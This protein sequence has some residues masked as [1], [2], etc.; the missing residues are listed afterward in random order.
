[1]R[2][3]SLLLLGLG[4]SLGA[5]ACGDDETGGSGGSGGAGGAGSTTAATTS[6]TTSSTSTGGEGGQ[7]GGEGGQ[8]GEGGGGIPIARG[9]FDASW[10]LSIAGEEADCFALGAEWVDVAARPQGSDG[11]IVETR[12]ACGDGDGRTDE[13]ALGA[14][15]L[16]FTLRSFDEEPVADPV[17][18]T[19]ELAEDGGTVAL[20]PIAFAVD[21]ARFDVSWIL[22][23]GGE[24]ATCE[25]AGADV[26][27]LVLVN[28]DTG[29]TYGETWPCPQG[30]GTTR[31]LPLG[32]YELSP[33]L[34][35]FDV[36]LHSADVV[37]AELDQ[38]DDVQR[39]DQFVF[40]I[41]GD[42]V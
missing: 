35:D 29:V 26:T 6:A 42:P 27:E 13:L 24:D 20:D 12:L 38:P 7:G 10:T 40:E 23:S 36:V 1:M 8:G 15:D 39:V 41:A 34:L 4:L 30:T 28:L 21:G 32:T 9:Q 2:P 17:T 3:V 14:Y 33:N 37:E 5:V 11:P 16:T 22:T 18:A 31:A 25:E 19:G